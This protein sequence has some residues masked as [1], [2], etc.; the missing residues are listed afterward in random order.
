MLAK[1]AENEKTPET[2]VHALRA[3]EGLG[4]LTDAQIKRALNDKHP[5]VREHAIQ[6]AEPRASFS[7]AL[8]ARLLAMADDPDRRVRFQCALSLGEINDARIIPA[9]V[10]ITMGNLNDKWTRAAALSAITHREDQ[11][12]HELLPVATKS[13]SD[14]LPALMGELGHILAAASPPEGLA[15]LLG[16]ILTYNNPS[17]LA[18]QM[19]AAGGFGTG[20]HARGP[21]GKGS[22][23][24]MSL[25][26]G[27]SSSLRE[28][29]ENLFK[30]STEVATD[31]KA[32]LRHLRKSD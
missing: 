7:P 5:A 12:L 26:T 30:R 14:S 18:W 27:G 25:C 19:A 28:Q 22:S 15:S 21:S 20:L 8:A 29:L 3:L 24:L 9:L 31:A 23:T 10:K 32:S 2:R 11:F 6:L 4:C 16:E 13:N 1:S 17:D